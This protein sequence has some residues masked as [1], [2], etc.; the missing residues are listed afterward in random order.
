METNNVVVSWINSNNS[1][2][3]TNKN[4]GRDKHPTPNESK[5]RGIRFCEKKNT[6]KECNRRWNEFKR[7]S[8]SF[9]I[10]FIR[11]AIVET[12]FRSTKE[13]HKLI[14]G[15]CISFGW[16]GDDLV[17]LWQPLTR[18]TQHRLLIVIVNQKV[19]KWNGWRQKYHLF[20]AVWSNIITLLCGKHTW[21]LLLM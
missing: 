20:N 5:W 14:Y 1:S 8:F 11:F 2:Q 6:R 15:F 18:T 9:F 17:T 3:N 10:L 21:C 19:C 4:I 16:K 12:I 7:I 13:K